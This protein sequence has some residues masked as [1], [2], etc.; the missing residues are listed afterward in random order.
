MKPPRVI[1]SLILI[2][3]LSPFIAGGD[4]T[5]IVPPVEDPPPGPQEPAPDPQD[6]VWSLAFDATGLGAFSSVWG[7]GPNDVFIVGGRTQQAEAYHYDGSQWSAMAV[8]SIPI[9]V[10]VYGFGP[11]DVLAVGV[12]GGAIHYDGSVWTELD[13]GTNEDLWGLWGS[14]PNDIWIVGGTI[15]QGDPLLLHYDGN[16]FHSVDFPDNDRAATSLFKVWGIG[17]KVFAVGENGLII[18]YSGGNWAQVPAGANADDDFVSLWGT[19]EDNI[20]AVGGRA[21]GRVATYDGSGWT[22]YKPPGRPGLNASFMDDPS[23]A[24]IGG[25]NGYLGRHPHGGDVPTDEESPTS[26]DIHA[27]WGDGQGRYYAVGGRFSQPLAGTALVRTL[28]DPGITPVPPLGAGAGS[29][30]IQNAEC[31]DGSSCTIDTCVNGK[32]VFTPINCDDGDPCTSDTCDRGVCLHTPIQCNDGN[33]C[34]VDTCENGACVF[35]P[36][37]C[38]DGDPCTVDTCTGGNCSSMPLNCDDGDPCTTEFCDEGDCVYILLDCDDGDPCTTDFCEDGACVNMPMDCDDGNPCTVDSCEN[39]VC[40]HDPL[41]G[42]SEICVNGV[43]EPAPECLIGGECNDGD[44]CTIDTCEDGHCVFTPMTCNDN[45]PCT[46]DDCVNGV[47]TFTP[48]PCNDNNPCTVDT[49]DNGTCVFTPMVCND[50]NPCT[51]DTCQNGTCVFTPM[52]CNDGNPC[53]V[54]TCDGGICVF[55]PMVCDDGDDC[56]TDACVG[57][58][59]VFTPIPGCSCDFES[60]CDLGDNCVGGACEA[61]AGPDVEIGVGG[62]QMC[63]SGPYKKL[64]HG[65]AFEVCEGFQGFYESYVAF[66]VTGFTP[67]SIVSVAR[68]ITLDGTSC[69]IPADCGPSLTCVNNLCSLT[70]EFATPLQMSGD[71]DG[72]GVIEGFDFG[73]TFFEDADQQAATIRVTLT[74]LGNPGVTASTQVSVVIDV[75]PF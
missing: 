52:V 45:N 2:L 22:T 20:V 53:T 1:R 34:T 19:S 29:A 59:C 10:W 37:D 9:L 63:I 72:D 40:V 46:V 30:C 28:G 50:G 36:V 3:C 32:C 75:I 74:E 67:G 60:D 42:V 7:S 66:R 23:F 21:T 73:T 18:Q 6:P 33:S 16:S 8:P 49:C 43:C 11:N 56:T 44:P 38:S 5:C 27:I 15:G 62:G 54:D 25:V 14:S 57:G 48:I 35:T 71:P 39:G 31:D 70:A 64:N 65:D 61:A 69:T 13:T 47:C 4:F 68:S 26:M 55:T 17:S 12:G 58:G 24:V 51:T 41:C